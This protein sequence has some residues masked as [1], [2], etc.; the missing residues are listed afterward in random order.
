VTAFCLCWQCG[1][2]EA[3]KVSPLTLP[4]LGRYL[5]ALAKR[6]AVIAVCE[7]EELDLKPYA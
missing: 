3:F 5:R 2:V 6:P 1:G 4:H 7:L